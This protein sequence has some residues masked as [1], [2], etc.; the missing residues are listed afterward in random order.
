[1]IEF[2]LEEKK[3]T[4]FV[5]WSEATLQ[6]ITKES[7]VFSDVD[8]DIVLDDIT[9]VRD[10][11]KQL[12][13][14]Q[15]DTSKGVFYK[16]SIKI[17]IDDYVFNGF[18]TNVTYQLDTDKAVVSVVKQDGIFTLEDNLNGLTV[19]YIDDL[20]PYKQTDIKY[21]VQP[22]DADAQILTLVLAEFM[23]GYILYQQI[24]DNAEQVANVVEASTPVGLPVPAPNFGAIISASLKA[25]ASLTF[26]AVT[27]VSMIKTAKQ[28]KELA[29]PKRRDDK[30][31]SLHELL[32]NPL[33]FLGYELV[34]DLPLDK[35]YIWASKSI[36]GGDEILNSSDF[37]Y[38]I[39]EIFQFVQSKF[40]AKFKVEGT[41]VYLYWENAKFW[42]QNIN[43]TL[44]EDIVTSNFKYNTD[45]HIASYL[46]NYQEDYQDE[47]TLE[48]FKGTSLLITSDNRDSVSNPNESNVKGYFRTNYPYALTNR[49][50]SLTGIENTVNTLIKAVNGAIKLFGGK[51]IKTL[52]NTRIGLPIISHNNFSIAKIVY[53]EGGK[54]PANHR[55]VLS[56]RADYDKYHYSKS[57]VTNANKTLKKKLEDVRITYTAKDFFLNVANPYFKTKDGSIGKFTDITW[58]FDRDY[59]D[60]NMEIR[61]KYTTNLKERFYESKR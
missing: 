24:K 48:R 52:S 25:V 39:L 6:A 1:M 42:E 12:Q 2:Y 34:T 59:A 43:Y 21:I 19:A 30:V 44:R 31:T 5:E 61:Y 49:K 32:R 53:L 40:N 15:N 28:I 11:L 57:F 35:N 3:V 18:I 8:A 26:T 36:T 7:D 29:V 51:S 55:D 60:A 10:A 16:P 41:K 56:A 50:N 22:L 45:E 33:D 54:I 58:R 4:E 20:Q 46:I 14:I 38:N 13:A 9:L 27:V 17:I 47:Y 23:Y 37:G